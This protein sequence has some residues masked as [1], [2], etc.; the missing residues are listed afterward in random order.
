MSHL[1]D[2]SIADDLAIWR[3]RAI[4]RYTNGVTMSIVDATEVR[5]AVVEIDDGVATI[6]VG[7]EAEEW[8]F[9]VGLL[10]DGTVIDSV[11]LLA[12]EGRDFHIVG[13]DIAARTVESRLERTLRLERSLRRSA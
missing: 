8:Y 11:V 1:A 5:G 2:S 6:L 3:V 9:P 12:G 7:D 4:G 10:P 13:P